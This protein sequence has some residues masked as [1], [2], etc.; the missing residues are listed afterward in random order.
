[1]V[2]RAEAKYV[3]ISPSKVRPVIDL[4]KGSRVA[5][6]LAQLEFTPKRGAYYLRKVLHSAVANAKSK[7][8]QVQTLFIS[9][10]IANPGPMLKRF[11]AASFGRASPIRKRTS[12]IMVELDTTE[13]LIKGVKIK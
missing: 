6:A 8:H 10:A 1:M 9:K 3:R 11:R 13:Q 5:E 2:S 7:G 4:I 12:H